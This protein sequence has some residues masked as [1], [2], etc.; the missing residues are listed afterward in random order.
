[1]T[2]TMTVY[3][4]TNGAF[5]RHGP[6][7]FV[8][9]VVLAFSLCLLGFRK[10]RHLQSLL[11]LVV[12]LIGLGMTTGCGSNLTSGAGTPSTV[13]LTGISG[14]LQVSTTFSLTIH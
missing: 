14:A 5:L 7:S 2:A 6:R 8:P 13:T 12:T 10:R 4:T 1:M 9:G 11:L 3:G